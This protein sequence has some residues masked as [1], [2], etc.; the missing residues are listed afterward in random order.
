MKTDRISNKRHQTFYGANACYVS[1][2][3]DLDENYFVLLGGQDGWL[4]SDHFIDLVWL[5][6]EGGYIRIPLRFETV[7]KGIEHVMNF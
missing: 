7:K 3:S 1:E 6:L 2:L 4:G 5:W